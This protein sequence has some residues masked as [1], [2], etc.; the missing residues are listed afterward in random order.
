MV[1]QRRLSTL[2]NI[3]ASFLSTPVPVVPILQAVIAAA[4]QPYA[5]QIRLSSPLKQAP[6]SLLPLPL[7]TPS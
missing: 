3:V 7:A 6:S 1:S 5:L 2:L 4:Q